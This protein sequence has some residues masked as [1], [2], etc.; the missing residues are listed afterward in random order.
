[1]GLRYPVIARQRHNDIEPRNG[2]ATLTDLGRVISIIAELATPAVVTSADLSPPGPKI[3]FANDAFARQTG[4]ATEELLGATP[5]ILQGTG[6][7]LDVLARFRMDLE[8]T[9]Q[10]FGE[11]L[12]Y[13][14]DGTPYVVAWRVLP[15][16]D[17]SGEVINWLSTQSDRTGKIALDH[18]AAG[19]G[20][21]FWQWDP[22]SDLVSVSPHLKYRLGGVPTPEPEPM[23]E[24]L[25]HVHPADRL[26]LFEI[27]TQCAERRVS[28][29]AADFRMRTVLGETCG[30]HLAANRAS[31]PEGIRL[32]GV[33]ADQTSNPV[34]DT[35][36]TDSG[37][38]PFAHVGDRIPVLLAHVGR[39]LRYLAVNSHYET[40]FGLPRSG[41][42]GQPVR[43]IAGEEVFGQ[44]EP[45]IRRVLGGEVLSTEIEAC[46]G[47]HGRRLHLDYLPARDRIG[48]V[49]GYYLTARDITNI[50]SLGSN[51]AEARQS[52][53]RFLAAASH[54]LRQPVQAIGLLASALADMEIPV[55]AARMVRQVELSAMELQ[56]Q[57]N[58][59]REISDLDAGMVEPEFSDVRLRDIVTDVGQ[60]LCLQA[61]QNGVKID[62]R[63]PDIFIVTDPVLL[64]R[65]VWNLATNAIV[66][67][68]DSILRITAIVNDHNTILSLEDNGPGIPPEDKEKV[69]EEFVQLTNPARDRRRGLGLGLSI[70]RRLVQMLGHE[71]ALR[72]GTGTGTRVDVTLGPSLSA[73][74]PA[75][76]TTSPS[77]AT[78]THAFLLIED[79]DSVRK[80]LG[81]RLETWGFRVF[82][83]GRFADAKTFL[84]SNTATID[85]AI[86][87][88][89]LPE[90]VS[91]V[92]VIGCLTKEH[93]IPSV[94]LTGDTDPGIL[95]TLAE[96]GSWVLHKPVDANALRLAIDRILGVRQT[97]V[98]PLRLP[99][100][101]NSVP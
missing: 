96:L 17:A 34:A 19:G 57:L 39:D 59:L 61:A 51:L 76:N 69:F 98:P 33:I 28:A 73:I 49:T 8:A 23:D 67:A 2:D 44:L 72:S 54:D 85:G 53:N 94:L 42:V 36:S 35:G 80:S 64:R 29:V 22:A 101:A 18:R 48:A 93:E 32:C 3:T 68:P 79:D 56:S 62:S 91:G 47:N 4:Y 86:V 9:G 88:L 52:R 77:H 84:S 14:K 12:N 13:K 97:A 20:G 65:V 41:I 43:T 83:F 75:E 55:K 89:R 63:V 70:V 90:G 71:I 78:D 25:R 58:V 100:N 66:H 7:N 27:V 30:F 11:T 5:K 50:S 45:I 16:R 1:M 74:K 60:E 92:N 87:D 95:R 37:V 99:P 46:F 10:F 31:S 81:I 24:W 15:L 40:V 38:P 6:T 26:A 21:G 82:S